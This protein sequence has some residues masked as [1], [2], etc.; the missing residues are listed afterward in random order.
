MS[1]YWETEEPVVVATGKNVFK[2]YEAAGK[3]QVSTPDWVKSGIKLPG[4]TVTVD[5]K[6]LREHPDAA[7]LFR[8][9]I[10]L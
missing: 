10:G 4:R 3:L 5:L 2:L 9:A 8:Q 6:A 7:G 1:K